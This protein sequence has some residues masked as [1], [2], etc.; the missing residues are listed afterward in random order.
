M[1]AVHVVVRSS[2]EEE[3]GE[4]IERLRSTAAEVMVNICDQVISFDRSSLGS[5]FQ[6]C[7]RPNVGCFR[8][9]KD[10]ESCSL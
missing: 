6:F 1:H 8:S 7:T 9:M 10:W 2:L 3:E 4:A 5:N